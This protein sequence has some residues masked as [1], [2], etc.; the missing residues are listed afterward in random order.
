MTNTGFEVD[1]VNF[2]PDA[3]TL[4]VWFSNKEDNCEIRFSDENYY[5]KEVV[6]FSG[7]AKLNSNYL[8]ADLD[9]D[10][11][12]EIVFVVS[13][14]FHMELRV[15]DLD[16]ENK[17]IQKKI[18]GFETDDEHYNGSISFALSDSILVIAYSTFFP[19]RKASRGIYSVNRRDYSVNWYYP[20]AEYIDKNIQIMHGANE[21]II[22]FGTAGVSNGLHASDGVFYTY[23]DDI[24]FR[25]KRFGNVTEKNIPVVYSGNSADSAASVYALN[26][27]GKLLWRKK[28]GG[29]SVWAKTE[30]IVINGK[31]FAATAPLRRKDAESKYDTLYIF[32]PDNGALFGKYSLTG[33][34][35]QLFKGGDNLWMVMKGKEIL[36]FDT[37]NK[38]VNSCIKDDRIVE[39]FDYF[40]EDEKF[41]FYYLIEGVGVAGDDYGVH[42]VLMRD[43]LFKYLPSLKL[44]S[45]I[46]FDRR[47]I[48]L[49]SLEEVPWLLRQSA[50][51]YLVI[52]GIVLSFFI[53]A[54]VMWLVQIRKS[55]NAISV[56]NIQLEEKQENIDKLTADLVHSEKLAMLGMVIG[57][58]AHEINSPL[59]AVSNGI[60]R[61]IKHLDDIE[62]SNKNFDLALKAADK[63]K[64]LVDKLLYSIQKKGEHFG[65]A[66]L[67]EAW[68]EWY[69]IYGNRFEMN[70][71]ILDVNIPDDINV[72][73]NVSDLHQALSNILMNSL[74]SVLG[75]GKSEKKINI[76]A[77]IEE[78]G[79]YIRIEDNGGGFPGEV[80]SNPVTPFHTIGKGEK[81]TGLGLWLVKNIVD[82]HGGQIKFGNTGDG[83]FV[84][85]ILKTTA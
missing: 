43:G 44:L 31:E 38:I 41:V 42:S 60:K 18:A 57:S 22:L 6:N 72:S 28:I 20:T 66:N 58:I 51:T 74:E 7:T 4:L 29:S 9:Y 39:I 37:K 17:I 71:V 79:C 63:C 64:L 23:E 85:L 33:R 84:E 21:E 81:G 48:T 8:I 19:K 3:D 53:F 25:G 69:Y 36:K 49:Y 52:T 14:S 16:A 56:K 54:L 61:G 59:G 75:A 1:E 35:K 13:E 68:N 62:L 47:A 11:L 34:L 83:A 55:H 12:D 77:K 15:L 10:G 65:S 45:Y 82:N 30:K 40:G 78:G 50:T 24:L 76:V 26:M 5:V 32:N 67:P 46:H 80:L 27:E 2:F 70:D 73:I